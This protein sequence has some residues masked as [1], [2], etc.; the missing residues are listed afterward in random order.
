MLLNGWH[1]FMENK[2]MMLLTV[3]L[4]KKHPST[5]Q[6]SAK[7]SPNSQQQQ[8]Q[9][10]KEAT[11]LELGKRKGT[12]HKTLQPGLQNPKDS[13][14]CHGKCISDSQ[15]NDGITEK[16]GGQIKITEMISDIFDAIQEFYEAI[17]DMKSHISDN[18]SSICNNIQTNNLSLRQ[19]NETLWCFEKVLRTIKACDNDNSFVNK[20]NE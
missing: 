18:N 13:A 17:N 8:F 11:S 1:L 10:E 19:K 2:N 20:M 4:R 6:A 9:R 3:E 12:S 7:N 16:G 14:G 15:N 5:T